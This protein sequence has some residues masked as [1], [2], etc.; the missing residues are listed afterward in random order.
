MRECRGVEPAPARAGGEGRGHGGAHA[1]IGVEQRIE[2]Q[3]RAPRGLAPGDLGHEHR[4]RLDGQ[5]SQRLL[6]GGVKLQRGGAR[7]GLAQ[8]VFEEPVEVRRRTPGRGHALQGLVWVDAR[9]SRHGEAR[10]HEGAGQGHAARGREPARRAGL[11][12]HGLDGLDHGPAGGLVVLVG[13]AR[14]VEDEGGEVE[15]RLQVVALGQRRRPR[16]S[17]AAASSG[18]P[19]IARAS[20]CRAAARPARSSRPRAARRRARGALAKTRSPIGRGRSAASIGRGRAG[21]HASDGEKGIPPMR[22]SR[23]RRVRPPDRHDLIPLD[24]GSP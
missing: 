15:G 2:P 24:G 16:A 13:H 19:S 18:R 21:M 5:G 23:R 20:R 12:E 22:G 9:S 8:Q 11:G 17:G 7:I 1:R 10:A 3:P 4:A 14:L 6:E